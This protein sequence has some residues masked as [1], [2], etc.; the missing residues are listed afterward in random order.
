MIF[1]VKGRDKAIAAI[2]VIAGRY[3]S[4]ISF[5]QSN[6]LSV[7]ASSYL[8]QTCPGFSSA[9]SNTSS[10]P[11]KNLGIRFVNGKSPEL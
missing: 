11:T 10:L 2:T 6:E 1:T 7:V 8:A 3:R 4:I 5:H 9:G